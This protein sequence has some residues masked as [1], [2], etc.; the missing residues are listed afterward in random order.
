MKPKLFT[1]FLALAFLV[2]AAA[3]WTSATAQTIL[4]LGDSLTAGYGLNAA[5]SFPSRLEAALRKSGRDVRVING[6]VSG[7]TTAGGLAR[8]DWLMQDKPDL[9]IVELGANDALRG[10]EPAA[11]RRNLAAIID[12]IHKTGATV[13][14]TGM[15]AP[16][17]MGSEY[18]K[19]F[20]ALFGNLARDHNIVFYPF[21]LEGVAAQPSLN[22]ND[23][24]HPNAE[25]VTQIVNRILP[26]VL[27]ALAG[28]K[29]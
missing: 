21:F 29:D 25:G 14:L 19:A 27:Q 3:G 8:L 4:A 13:L 1:K 12:G 9:V 16:P 10:I 6:G 24:M 26:T 20:N 2:M 17:N 18:G 5:D 23:G 7:D 15:L 22:Q 11:T 28:V